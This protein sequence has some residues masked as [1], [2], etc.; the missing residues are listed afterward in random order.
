MEISEEAKNTI[1]LRLLRTIA[2]IASK[3]Y[4]ERIWIEGRGPEVDDFDET[5]IFFS[6]DSDLVIQHL[7]KFELSENQKTLLKNFKVKFENVAG[8][9]YWP[10]EFIDTPEW[11][12][13]MEM[14]EEVLQAFDY[15]PRLSWRL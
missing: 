4:Q 12:Q 2:V 1:L 14:A 5:Y 6:E 13:I 11:K 15:K 9:L 8:D 3:E 10:P 7:E